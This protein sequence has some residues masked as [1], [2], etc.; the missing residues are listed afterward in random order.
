[1]SVS[2]HSLS[3][4][5][6]MKS[7]RT[8]EPEARWILVF[9]EGHGASVLVSM[10]CVNTT[11]SGPNSLCHSSDFLV[12]AKHRMVG[13]PI[14][15][16]QSHPESDGLTTLSQG[17][18]NL[19]MD[20]ISPTRFPLTRCKAATEHK[21]SR[22]G[23]ATGDWVMTDWTEDMR[24]AGGTNSNVIDLG[25]HTPIGCL[26]FIRTILYNSS[27]SPAG[28]TERNVE[29]ISRRVRTDTSLLL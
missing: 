17:R 7:E 14:S 8:I 6:G 5:D 26:I 19:V 20:S 21:S 12:E 16:E 27:Q 1:M 11:K 29:R 18:F 3:M 2:L 23:G 4:L 24:F 22:R 10:C 9:E 28:T 13:M 25:N 15:D